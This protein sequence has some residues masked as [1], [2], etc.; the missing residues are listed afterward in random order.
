MTHLNRLRHTPQRAGAAIYSLR[1][2]FAHLFCYIQHKHIVISFALAATLAQ[3]VE[4]PSGLYCGEVN[5]MSNIG[6]TIPLF[7][8]PAPS[9]P[10]LKISSIDFSA[11]SKK[12]KDE[13]EP[14]VVASFITIASPQWLTQSYCLFDS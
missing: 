2:N 1:Y 3:T 14:W 5:F 4:A 8:H 10:S 11:L 9:A 12:K 6:R 13:A 7:F